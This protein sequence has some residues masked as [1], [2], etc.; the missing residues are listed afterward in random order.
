MQLSEAMQ[1]KMDEYPNHQLK[2]YME[3]LTCACGEG[4][5]LDRIR[6]YP[7]F[8][9]PTVIV[10]LVALLLYSYKAHYYRTPRGDLIRESVI[11]LMY[12]PIVTCMQAV[13]FPCIVLNLLGLVG[14]A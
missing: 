13:F 11:F 10:I 3:P 9:Q 6:R 1:K 7:W 4:T 5:A 2:F 14:L 8:S 12:W